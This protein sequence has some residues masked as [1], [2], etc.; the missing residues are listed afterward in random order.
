MRRIGVIDIL[1]EGAIGRV[2]WYGRYGVRGTVRGTVRYGEIS[3][4][5]AWYGWCI[6]LQMLQKVPQC[7]GIF[8]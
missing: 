5:T 2:A 4:D 8:L 7:K 1:S 3:A 6:L